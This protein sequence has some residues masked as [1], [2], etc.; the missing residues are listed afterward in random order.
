M[1]ITMESV[2]NQRIAEL[3]NSLS[4]SQSEFARRLEM[5][6]PAI[7]RIESGA[8]KPSTRT[9]NTIS[10]TFGVSLN[11]LLKGTGE[12]MLPE[13]EQKNSV[14]EPINW[15]DEAFKQ[16]NGHLETLKQENEWLKNLVS[17]M[18]GSVNF[19]NGIDLVGMIQNPINTVR[20]A[21]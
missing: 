5:T 16:L 18:A 21:A 7:N 1:L 9:I 15:K 11:W 2:I 10:K 12:M 8:T 19:P 20:A 14:T 17:K 13:S 3:R 4:L 6:A